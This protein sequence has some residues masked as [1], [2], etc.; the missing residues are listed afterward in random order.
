MKFNNLGYKFNIV[1]QIQRKAK[2]TKNVSSKTMNFLLTWKNEFGLVCVENCSLK[3]W[4]YEMKILPQFFFRCARSCHVGRQHKF[5]KKNCFLKA[6]AINEGKWHI[7]ASC[8]VSWKSQEKYNVL[9]IPVLSGK[10][11]SIWIFVV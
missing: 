9:K 5:L 4:K 8:L 11:L 3:A 6:S 7:Q 1:D 10:F 2:L